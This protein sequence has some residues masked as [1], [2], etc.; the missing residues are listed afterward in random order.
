VILK[1][2]AWFQRGFSNNPCSGSRWIHE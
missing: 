1:Y 2:K